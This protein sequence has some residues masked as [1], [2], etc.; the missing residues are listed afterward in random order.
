MLNENR[1][2]YSDVVANICNYY[3]YVPGKY[4]SRADLANP[5][6]LDNTI[7]YSDDEFNK[8]SFYKLA[9]IFVTKDDNKLYTKGVAWTVDYVPHGITLAKGIETKKFYTLEGFGRDL[10]TIIGLII[11]INH[12]LEL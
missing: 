4:Y 9:P 3:F 5:I 10:N 8:R 7:L 1:V 6:T 2:Y 11:R 12:L